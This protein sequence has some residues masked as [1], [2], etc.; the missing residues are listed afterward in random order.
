VQVREGDGL[1]VVKM[2]VAFD[3]GT[4]AACDDDGEVCVVVD[5]GIAHAAAVKEEAVI[6]EGALPFFGGCEFAQMFREQADVEGVDLLQLPD[7]VCLALS[8][9]ALFACGLN[10]TRISLSDYSVPSLWVSCDILK[11]D[12]TASKLPIL[13]IAVMAV[14]AEWIDHGG[15]Q[16]R[17]GD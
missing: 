15:V 5:V 3:S 2:A 9:R 17:I 12:Q 16:A 14:N 1:L 10:V 11:E 7:Q 8:S 4:G 6:E 13:C